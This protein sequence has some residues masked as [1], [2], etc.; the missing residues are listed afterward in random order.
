[1]SIDEL[2]IIWFGSNFKVNGAK[3]LRKNQQCTDAWNLCFFDICCVKFIVCILLFAVCTWQL[4]SLYYFSFMVCSERIHLLGC[5]LFWQGLW[6][7]SWWVIVLPFRQPR[8]FLEYHSIICLVVRKF[9]K[10]KHVQ[11][12]LSTILV[13]FQGNDHENS[14]VLVIR[15]SKMWGSSSV[16]R[17]CTAPRVVWT[18]PSWQRTN[19]A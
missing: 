17:S 15:A 3:H 4:W 19:A 18:L 9:G 7:G 10:K 16:S 2:A 11:N 1:M 8:S 5:D 14:H 13:I 6:E 12:C